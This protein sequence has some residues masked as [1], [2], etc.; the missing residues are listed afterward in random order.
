MDNTELEQKWESVRKRFMKSLMVNTRLNSLAENADLPNWPLEGEDETP[1][2]YID[3]GWQEIEVLPELTENDYAN[4]KLLIRIMDETLAFDD[5]FGEMTEQ[6]DAVSDKDDTMEKTFKRLGI[7]TDF[8]V[9]LSN[10]SPETKEFC[11]SQEFKT[12]GEF[13]NFVQNVAQNIVIKGDYRSFLNSLANYDETGIAKVL[14]F[15]P[16]EKGVHLQEGLRLAT[17]T[18]TVEERTALLNKYGREL[19]G[20][21]LEKLPAYSDKQ[22]KDIETG[23]QDRFADYLDYFPEEAEKL[24]AVIHGSESLE[25][26]L[27]VLKDS[28]KELIIHE[29]IVSAVTGNPTKNQPAVKLTPK[30]EA[31]SN[32]DS[33]GLFG[34]I[35]KLFGG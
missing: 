18:L 25:R 23:L 2:K 28:D 22:I 9:K 5:P 14:P 1:E 20:K 29:V 8:P 31:K 13:V 11:T 10:L 7:P 17:E 12:V 4:L 32:K 15:R 34:S 6:S 19:S 33:G 24:R 16:G 30:G 3:F 27:M 26:F 35:K 21:E